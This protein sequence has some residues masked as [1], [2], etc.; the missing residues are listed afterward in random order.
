LEWCTIHIADNKSTHTRGSAGV[1]RTKA[2]LN[3]AEGDHLGLSLLRSEDSRDDQAGEA[4]PCYR[5]PKV[6]DLA[7][8]PSGSSSL[9]SDGSCDGQTVVR[10]IGG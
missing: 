10:K 2:I 9:R 5:R 3:K 8:G 1:A 7:L 6:S 4:G